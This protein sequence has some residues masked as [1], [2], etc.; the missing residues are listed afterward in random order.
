[1]SWLDLPRVD[2]PE[3]IDNPN[4]PLA[5]LAT[6]MADVARTNAW[7]GGTRAVVGNVAT[8]LRDVPTEQPVRIL[9]IGTGSADIPRALVDWGC[10]NGRTITVVGVDNMWPMLTI[11]R[12]LTERMPMHHSALTPFPSPDSLVPRWESQTPRG[13][14]HRDTLTPGPSPNSL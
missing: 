14:M 6:S 10:K 7:F 9:D 2:E 13:P 11:A 8:L 12:E 1:M 3:E 5:D 4:Q